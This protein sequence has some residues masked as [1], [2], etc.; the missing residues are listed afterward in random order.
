[1]LYIKKKY[2]HRRIDCVVYESFSYNLKKMK[3]G[4]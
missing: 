3:Y 1:M 4:L 2:K